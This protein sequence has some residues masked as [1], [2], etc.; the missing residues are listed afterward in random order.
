MKLFLS[1]LLILGSFQDLEKNSNRKVISDDDFNYTFFVSTK[2]RSDFKNK[3]EYFW[4]KSGK[5]HSSQGGVN[6]Q[7]LHGSYTKSYIQNGIAEQGEFHYGLKDDTWKLWYENGKLKEVKSWTRGIASGS[8]K[9][10]DDKGNLVVS[11]KFSNNEKNGRWINH[12]TKDTLYFKKGEKIVKEVE[13]EVKKKK[14]KEAKKTG[15]NGFWIKTKEFFKDLFKKKT[16]QEKE[17]AKRQKEIESKQKELKKKREEL[18][19]KKQAKAN[20][21]KKQ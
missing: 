18:A 10:F 16:P 21:S 12:G 7:L 19:K 8:Y 20:T 11:G 9:S 13:E 17:E 6:G 15:L 1:L 4:F 5:I 14:D 2:D 3:K